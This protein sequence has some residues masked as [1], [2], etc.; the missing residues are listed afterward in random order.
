VDDGNLGARLVEGNGV[1]LVWAPDGPG[2]SRTGTDWYQAQQTCQH[3]DDE[4]LALAPEPQDIWRLP[5]VDEAVRSM[6]RHGQNSGGQWDATTEQATYTVRP[7]KE[8]PLWNT[9]SQVI[10]WWTATG[11]DDNHAYMIVYDGRVWARD[12]D[13]RQDYLG[14]RCVRPPSDSTGLDRLPGEPVSGALAP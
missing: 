5:T 4:G 8:S 9:H 1:T 7:D 12:K 6:A 10:Y 13:L 11:V 14:Y 3:L 2:W